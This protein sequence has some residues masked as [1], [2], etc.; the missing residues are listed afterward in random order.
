MLPECACNYGSEGYAWGVECEADCLSSTV[1][2]G[3]SLKPCRK[4]IKQQAR[5]NE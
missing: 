2:Q 5:E 4:L 1:A 3:C